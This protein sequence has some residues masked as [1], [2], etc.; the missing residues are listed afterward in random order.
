MEVWLAAE[1]RV[2]VP[3]EKFTVGAAVG[4]AREPNAA[5]L[6]L[7]IIFTVVEIVL[8]FPAGAELEVRG[9]GDV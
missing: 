4:I 1:D 9:C 5:A 6:K 3:F 8:E 2:G 7:K